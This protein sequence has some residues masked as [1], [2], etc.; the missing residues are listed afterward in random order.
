MNTIDSKIFSL[1]IPTKMHRKFVKLCQE[2]HRTISATIRLI[3]AAYMKQ[4]GVKDV[5]EEMPPPGRQSAESLDNDSP[6]PPGDHQESEGEVEEEDGPGTTED[7]D[8]STEPGGTDG[9]V[10]IDEDI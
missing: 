1:K 6:P 9:G 2:E 4:R 8:E 10:E 5:S 7:G 3:I